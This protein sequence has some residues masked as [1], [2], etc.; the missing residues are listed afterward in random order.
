MLPKKQRAHRR[1]LLLE[2]NYHFCRVK[3]F[4]DSLAT[5]YVSEEP[6]AHDKLFLCKELSIDRKLSSLE[7]HKKMMKFC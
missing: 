1:N 2:R 4:L 5:L 7:A 3:G 6:E